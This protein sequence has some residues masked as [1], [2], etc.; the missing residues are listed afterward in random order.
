MLEMLGALGGIILVDLA[1]SGDNAL[2]IG[3]AAAGL[4][5][6]ERT[7]AIVLGG[8]GAIVLRIIFAIA[9]TLLLQLPFVQ[10]IGGLVLLYIATRLLMERKGSHEEQIDEQ[11]Q[12]VP[13]AT[14]TAG[15][16][17]TGADGT[18]R[19][20]GASRGFTGALLT[21]LV[22]DVTMSLD[23]VLAIG[24]L[25]HG[26]IVVLIFGL[27]VSIGLVLAGS[28]LVASLIRR[29]PWL[30]DVAALVLGWTAAGMVLHD[31]R[32]GPALHDLIPATEVVIYTLGVGAVLAIDIWLRVRHARASEVKAIVRE[33]TPGQQESAPTSEKE[34]VL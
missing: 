18:Q 33:E 26:E 16:D 11:A 20:G 14:E 12:I 6:R 34:N 29:L 5:R 22:A 4:P 3:A 27:L 19:P 31:L 8:A 1:L 7:Q 32:L 25:A 24:A 17:R 2:V 9:A 30:L 23:N 13:H 15:A 10:A 28:A 21:I